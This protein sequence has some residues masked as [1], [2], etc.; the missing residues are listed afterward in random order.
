M[1]TAVTHE[2]YCDP[3]VVDVVGTVVNMCSVAAQE[4]KNTPTPTFQAGFDLFGMC[5][6]I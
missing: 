2:S 5:M 1:N 4:Q 6:L 3:T